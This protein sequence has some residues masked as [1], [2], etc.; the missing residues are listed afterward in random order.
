MLM[1]ICNKAIESVHRYCLHDTGEL[2]SKVAD[3][4]K[5]KSDRLHVSI[6]QF[7][8]MRN[9]QSYVKT[10]ER[11]IKDLEIAGTLIF[12]GRAKIYLI[13]FGSED[14]L[15]AFQ[16]L[17]KTSN[18]D[19]NSRGRPCKEKLSKVLCFESAEKACGNNVIEIESVRA[20][21]KEKL[22]VFDLEDNLSLKSC[23]SDLKLGDLYAKYICN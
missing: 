4:Q 16:Q 6:T 2:H 7:D 18:V 3:T 17:L 14:K 12:C 15:R 5:H 11:W 10:L 1:D 23:F 19:V 8:H 13:L 22:Q 21:Y 9:Q 20:K